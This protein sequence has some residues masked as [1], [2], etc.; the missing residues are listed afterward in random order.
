M[1]KHF[2]AM[3]LGLATAAL[4]VSLMSATPAT[5]QQ[6]AVK[7][8]WEYLV[9]ELSQQEAPVE[10]KRLGEDGWELVTLERMDKH[11]GATFYLK[12]L[13]SR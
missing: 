11:V 8:Q 2:S 3:C 5:S 1:R 10:L 4:S 7:Q 13:K 12:R 6:P 9:S